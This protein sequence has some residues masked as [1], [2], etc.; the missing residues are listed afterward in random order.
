[1][2]PSAPPRFSV[3]GI[4]CAV[5]G[6]GYKAG[7]AQRPSGAGGAS[8]LR[9]AFAGGRPTHTVPAG[10]HI[11]HLLFGSQLWCAKN[12]AVIEF[13]MSAIQVMPLSGRLACRR[14]LHVN[15][16]HNVPDLWMTD[17]VHVDA[18]RAG[19]PHAG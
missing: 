6:C 8:C 19:L 15:R 12:R 13:E 17:H 11:S 16:R 9:F 7:R 10:R 18:F 3:A 5:E 4:A 2:R 14:P 1:M